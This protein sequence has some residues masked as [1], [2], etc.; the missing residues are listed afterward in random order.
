MLQRRLQLLLGDLELAQIYLDGAEL[1][2]DA[3]LRRC[4]WQSAR[5]LYLAV[6]EAANELD[7]EGAFNLQ[8]MLTSVAERLKALTPD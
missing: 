7:A 5:T 4:N 8:P 3:E 6:G 2:R 1:L